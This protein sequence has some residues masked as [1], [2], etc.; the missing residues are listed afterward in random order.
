MKPVPRSIETTILAK[1]HT[2]EDAG[3][4]LRRARERLNLRVRDVE[5]AS[6]KIAEKYHNDEFEIL[7]NRLSEIENR[8][9]VP[10][11]HKLYSLCAIYRLHFE[12][13]LEWF[14]IALAS[15]PTDAKFA[16][17]PNTH[18]VG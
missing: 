5:L 2:M 18:A 10:S 17:V 9:L 12:E 8:G 15:A 11:V 6:Q 1:H 7:I 13:V 4:K 16:Q 14:G 3:Q